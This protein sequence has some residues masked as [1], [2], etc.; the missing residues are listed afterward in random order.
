MYCNKNEMNE[1]TN[2]IEI[3]KQNKQL[4]F[5]YKYFLAGVKLK[6]TSKS[7][8]VGV[9]RTFRKTECAIRKNGKFCKKMR[10][11]RNAGRGQ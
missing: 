8:G 6:F 2:Q 4:I 9:A 10:K 5:I 1:R 7:W 11:H 3:N